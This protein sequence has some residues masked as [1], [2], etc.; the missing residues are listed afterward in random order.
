MPNQRSIWPKYHPANSGI[1][2][3]STDELKSIQE[4]VTVDT[5]LQRWQLQWM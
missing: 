1:N 2:Q 5:A 3:K 4:K